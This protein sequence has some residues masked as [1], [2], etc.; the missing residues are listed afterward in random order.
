MKFSAK[1]CHSLTRV[2]EFSTV[3]LEMNVTM[4]RTIKRLPTKPWTDFPT[5]SV[6]FNSNSIQR[7]RSAT[8]VSTFFY[9]HSNSSE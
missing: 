4:Q 6:E 7:F 2:D 5:F 1:Q 9:V 3:T 8:F